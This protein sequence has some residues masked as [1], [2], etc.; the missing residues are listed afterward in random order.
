MQ[1]ERPARENSIKTS[2]REVW[3]NTSIGSYQSRRSTHRS[4]L[5]SLK[6]EDDLILCQEISYEKAGWYNLS[7]AVKSINPESE[8]V[9][10]RS[11][12]SVTILK[13][14]NDTNTDTFSGTR[15]FHSFFG[16]NLCRYQYFSSTNFLIPIP[17]IG[18]KHLQCWYFFGTKDARYRFWYLQI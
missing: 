11:V 6:R 5:S 7:P 9:R 3:E 15:Y 17:F 4:D 10:L 2:K 13:I 12:Q 16:T 18:T 1:V 14:L 8:G